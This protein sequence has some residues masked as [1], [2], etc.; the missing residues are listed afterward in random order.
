MVEISFAKEPYQIQ[1]LLQ[2]RADDL[3]RTLLLPSYTFA[4]AT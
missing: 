3:G 2:K 4:K 1:A